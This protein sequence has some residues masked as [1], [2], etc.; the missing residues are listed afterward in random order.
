MISDILQA[1]QQTNK[2]TDA[3]KFVCKFCNKGF[4]KESTLVNHVCERK[5]RYQQEKEKG[6]QW[7]LI[8]YLEFYKMTQNTKPK[9]YDDFV[10]SPY[11]TAFVK[12]GRYCVDIRCI[13]FVSFT[14][15]LLKNNKKLDYWTS[16]KL[17]EEWL[18]NY[19]RTE[20][21][22]DALERGINEISSYVEDHPDLKNGIQDYFRYG[23][24]NRICYHISSGR[25]SPWV[26][27]NS[28]S[29]V[30]FLSGLTEDQVSMIIQWIDPEYWQSKFKHST[31]DVAWAKKILT[32]AGL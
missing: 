12:F 27:F 20:S 31:E 21:V 23:N 14:N 16:D 2:G 11:Y 26:V 17:Y 9:N 7:G 10:D 32:T 18:F 15:W 5:R 28:N 4:A 30:E 29:G 25:I 1:Y 13:N 6:V 8:S 19:L 24:N 22:Q 3:P